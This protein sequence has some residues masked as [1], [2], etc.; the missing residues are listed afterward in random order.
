MH[1]AVYPALPP[2]VLIYLPDGSALKQTTERMYVAAAIKEFLGDITIHTLSSL[3]D[4]PLRLQGINCD[5]CN[6]RVD[7][8]GC[9]VRVASRP[10]CHCLTSSSFLV[11]IC[12]LSPLPNSATPLKGPAFR[13]L[14][15]HL[16]T[17]AIAF[18]PLVAGTVYI[19]AGIGPDALN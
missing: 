19:S 11:A 8:L 17:F 5:N 14:P 4:L 9:E 3:S 16:L 6:V 18:L 12:I 13:P 1:V 7:I 10:R 2:Q 15:G